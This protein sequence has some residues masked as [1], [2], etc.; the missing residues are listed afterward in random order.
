MNY[1]RA[2]PSPR[3]RELIA[4]YRL[5]HAEGEKFLELPPD[6]TFPGFSLIKQ[7]PRIKQLIER[8]GA[9]TILDYGSGKG[10]QYRPMPFELEGVGSWDSIAEYWDVDNVICYDPCYEPYSKLPQEKFD[11]VISTDVLEHCPEEDIP[12]IIEEIFNYASLFVFASVACFPAQKR[13]PKGENA[14]CTIKPVAW[15]DDI[16][17]R[18]SGRR[19]KVLWEV[20]V[21]SKEQTAEGSRLIEERLG[22]G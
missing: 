16:L 4:Q 19:P 10:Y 7:V 2:N 18:A 20:W 15:W 8:T 5:M 22:S 11:G 9:K 6:E 3:Y 13:L 14:H 12:W 1:N 17:R 21:Y